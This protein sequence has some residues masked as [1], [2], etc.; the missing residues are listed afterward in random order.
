MKAIL[1]YIYNSAAVGESVDQLIFSQ[2]SNTVFL[3]LYKA[4][5]FFLQNNPK[6]LDPSYKMDLDLRDC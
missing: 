1:V 4:E 2:F 3:W 5:F 6:N